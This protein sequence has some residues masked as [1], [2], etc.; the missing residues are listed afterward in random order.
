MGPE[1]QVRWSPYGQELTWRGRVARIERVDEVTQTARMIVE[2][3]GAKMLATVAKGEYDT[4]G[5]AIGMFCKVE[6]PGQELEGA[7][8]VPRE[9]LVDNRSVYVFERDHSS[10]NARIGRLRLREVP[11]LRTL[12]ELV[13]VNSQGRCESEDCGL[14]AGELVVLPPLDRVVPGMRARLREE[15]VTTTWTSPSFR[16][17]DAGKTP[18]VARL[19]GTGTTGVD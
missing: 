13:L 8:A 15:R 18:Q 14:K 19:L 1:V 3:R 10:K 12:G 17:A 11:I 2:V 4:T 7:L 16:L 6:L 9:A 5:L